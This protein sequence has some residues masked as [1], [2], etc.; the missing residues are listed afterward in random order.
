MTISNEST[1]VVMSN[2]KKMLF[3]L[4]ELI[5]LLSLPMPF[6]HLNVLYVITAILIVLL[7]KFVRKEKWSDYGFKPLQSKAFI[8]SVLIGLLLGFLDNY[9]TEPLINK[10]AGAEPDLSSFDGVRGS[11]SGLIGMLALGWVVGGFF[12]ES[13]FRGYLFHRFVSIIQ[14]PLLH[15]IVCIFLISVVFSLAHTYQGISGIIGTFLFSVVSGFLFFL[16]RQNVWYLIF[17]HGFYDT[18]GIFKL[19]AGS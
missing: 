16:F 13:F 1:E 14:N 8:L 9:I 6:L 15:K 11:I 2:S 10:L 12:E 7:S 18:V 5:I 17:I 19:Y 4:I 3:N